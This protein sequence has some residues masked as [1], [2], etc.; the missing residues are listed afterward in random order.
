[1]FK[2]ITLTSWALLLLTSAANAETI[3]L[4]LPGNKLVTIDSAAP[5]TTTAALS[6]SGLGA[7][8]SLVGIDFRP[9]TG[10]LYALAVA[11]G[12]GRV[13]QISRETGAATAV[14]AGGIP[15]VGTHFGFDFNPTADRIRVVSDANQ[16]LRVHPDTGALAAIDQNL[17]YAADDVHATIDPI[18]GA[19]AYTDNIDGATATTL[20][21]IDLATCN[22]VRQSPPN[23]G[24]LHSVGSHNIGQPL[25]SVGFDISG[26]SGEAYATFDVGDGFKLYRIDSSSGAACL[27]GA[28]A[29]D[30]GVRVIGLAVPVSE[31]TCVP[32]TTAL[33][34]NHDR[35]RLTA[36]WRTADGQ[37]GFGRAVEHI[38]DSGYFWFFDPHNTEITAKVLNGC[39]LNDSYWVFASGLTNVEVTLTV[40]DT[41]TGMAWTFTN[42]LHHAFQPIQ[43]VS[44]IASCP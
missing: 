5:G 14:G 13:Y 28:L 17:A 36:A 30:A 16:N 33:C 6:V 12:N 32:S 44:A 23:D 25:Q 27:V 15:L 7:G 18:V 20:Y 35:F 39:E 42:P 9:K 41:L 21:G 8:E 37:S 19:A 3:W 34:L 4:L 38:E 40:T 31:G 43:D 2:R 26:Q 22:L 29:G 10:A 1:M 11:T 24:I